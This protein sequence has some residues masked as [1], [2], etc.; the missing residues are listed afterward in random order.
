MTVMGLEYL[1]EINYGDKRKVSWGGIHN[2]LK[3]YS[4]NPHIIGHGRTYYKIKNKELT[5]E[6]TR[7]DDIKFP[8]YIND[9]RFHLMYADLTDGFKHYIDEYISSDA[10]VSVDFV[11]YFEDLSDC[12]IKNIHADIFFVSI[13]ELRPTRKMQNLPGIWY[14]HCPEGVI[15]I[16]NIIQRIHIYQSHKINVVNTIGFGDMFAGLMWKYSFQ[17]PVDLV[18]REL[19]ELI[20]QRATDEFHDKV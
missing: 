13:K 3:T 9:D 12:F 15:R 18:L 7:I 5:K 2:F 4:A 14:F 17:Q 11:N 19:E 6:S 20:I 1:D 10:I 8:K 16:E